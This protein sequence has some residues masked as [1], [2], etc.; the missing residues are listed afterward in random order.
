MESMRNGTFHNNTTSDGETK[1]Q[2]PL[3]LF[4]IS[5]SDI[6]PPPGFTSSPQNFEKPDM[7]IW[8][9]EEKSAFH[10]PRA[11]AFHESDGQQRSQRVISDAKPTQKEIPMLK[12]GR[13]LS[14]EDI[15][16]LKKY[17]QMKHRYFRDRTR[18][19]NNK[20]RKIAHRKKV[21]P[22]LMRVACTK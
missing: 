21:L 17:N 15:I 6:K 10:R 4:V 22:T 7:S 11:F 1:S 2:S 9:G 16:M 14:R 18:I 19:R 3:P 5:T 12:P 13:F 8:S 20:I